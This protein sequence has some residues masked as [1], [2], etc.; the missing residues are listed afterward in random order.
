MIPD[1]MEANLLKVNLRISK[2]VNRLARKKCKIKDTL[3]SINPDAII[4]TSFL[5]A[6]FA[7]Y[8]RKL[9]EEDTQFK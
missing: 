9:L 3:K 8:W 2:Y 7:I 6:Y 4:V 5:S 1:R